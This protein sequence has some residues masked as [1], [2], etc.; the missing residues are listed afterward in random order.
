MYHKVFS[1]NTLAD[2]SNSY[3]IKFRF[4]KKYFD[5]DTADFFKRF[6][7]ALIP[8]N[9]FF[10]DTIEHNPD[11]WGPFWIYTFLIFIIAACGSITKYLGGTTVSDSFFQ[12]FIPVAASLIYGIGFLLPLFLYIAM[13]CFGTKSELVSVICTYGYSMSIYIPVIIACS[14]PI[15]VSI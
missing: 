11:L 10:H 7:Q 1:Q 9:P 12:Q 14:L 8:F 2:L 6:L 5:I 13:K 3:L 15:G 4:L